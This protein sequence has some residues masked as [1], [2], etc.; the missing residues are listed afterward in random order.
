MHGLRVVVEHGFGL[1][2]VLRRAAF[3]H[4]GGQRPGAAGKADQWH[5][6]I[7]LTA[8]GA[9][10]VHHITQ[11]LLWI[12]DRQRFDISHAA[13]DFL[14]TRA[15]AGFKIQA[16]AHGVGDGQDVREQNRRI[17]LRVTIQRLDGDLAGQLRVLH[18][19]DEV[20]RFGAG[21]AVLRQVTTGLAHHPHRGDVDRLLEQ[22]T[23]EAVVLQGGHG[24][25]RE[26]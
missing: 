6:A 13:D 14:E 9:H 15:F 24:S 4:I 21:S 7:Q 2:E 19:L 1:A 10:G 23:K 22:S 18:Q 17:E 26:K 12:G 5:A 11:I 25:S 3:D 16:L 8:N 20:T